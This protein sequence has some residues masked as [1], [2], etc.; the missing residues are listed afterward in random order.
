MRPR[1]RLWPIG[2]IALLLSVVVTAQTSANT[3][4]PTKAHDDTRAATAN[5]MKP[6][7]C[8]GITLTDKYSGSGI[9]SSGSTSEL[10]TG[11]NGGDV[12]SSGSGDDCVLGGDGNDTING[13]TGTDVCIGG[14]GTDSFLSCETQIQ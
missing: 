3:V 5:T 4:A 7:D 10:V 6:T 9:F 14:P 1:P 13:G 8:A 2:L 11:S 12:I